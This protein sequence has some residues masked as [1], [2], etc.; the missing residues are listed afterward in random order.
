MGAEGEAGLKAV[1]TKSQL[2]PRVEGAL[3]QGWPFRDV[4][5][6]GEGPGIYTLHQPPIECVLPQDGE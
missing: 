2:T 6:W 4:L 5:S 3:K 1:T